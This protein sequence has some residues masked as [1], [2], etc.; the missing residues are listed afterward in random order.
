MAAK[1]RRA[2]AASDAQPGNAGDMSGSQG[3]RA[4]VTQ[5]VGAL[6]PAFIGYLLA[7]SGDFVARSQC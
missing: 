7:G 1:E 5:I 2:A 4:L 6:S 3:I